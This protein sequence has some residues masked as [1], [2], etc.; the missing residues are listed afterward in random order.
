M[1]QLL[2]RLQEVSRKAHKLAQLVVRLQQDKLKLEE[3]KKTL[4]HQMK[5]LEGR[6]EE[7]LQ[8]YEAVK[9]AK[10]LHQTEDRETVQA[11]I[12]LYLKEIDD[13][14]KNFGE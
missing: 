10:S 3:E 6:H 13:C 5:E 4:I 12:D 7:A 8:R 2:P 14:L 9:L 1:D 11:K